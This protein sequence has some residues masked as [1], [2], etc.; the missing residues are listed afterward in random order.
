MNVIVYDSNVSDSI[1]QG[2]TLLGIFFYQ[3]FDFDCVLLLSQ[4]RFWYLQTTI[5]SRSMLYI[6]FFYSYGAKPFEMLSHFELLSLWHGRS[7]PKTNENR[8]QASLLRRTFIHLNIFYSKR[9]IK[10]TFMIHLKGEQKYSKYFHND[11]NHGNNT[12]RRSLHTRMRRRKVIND[13]HIRSTLNF[14]WV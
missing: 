4:F 1:Q 5:Q 9:N 11:G 2:L 6:F 8:I 14:Q 3:C 7:W 13:K 12:K 10:D